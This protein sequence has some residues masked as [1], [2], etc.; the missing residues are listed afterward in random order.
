MVS[1]TTYLFDGKGDLVPIERFSERIHKTE[2]VSGA[3]ELIV[4]HKPVLRKEYDNYI[5]YM[6]RDLISATLLLARGQK[7]EFWYTGLPLTVTFEPMRAAKDVLI[8]LTVLRYDRKL[9]RARADFRELTHNIVTAGYI[10]CEHIMKF[11]PHRCVQE[12]HDLGEIDAEL[13]RRA[14]RG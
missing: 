12:L 11:I 9:A 1:I 4:D 7:A 14:R 10:Y 5:N 13:H 3:I 2:D 8:T 6:W